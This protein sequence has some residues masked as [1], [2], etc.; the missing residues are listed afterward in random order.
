MQSQ[1]DNAGPSFYALFITVFSLII[2]H[3]GE[4]GATVDLQLYVNHKV[5]SCITSNCII[6]HINNCKAAYAPP[7][8]LGHRELFTLYH[9]DGKCKCPVSSS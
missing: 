3:A 9:Q 6:F 2:A 5:Y 8:T 1:V 7:S 4:R